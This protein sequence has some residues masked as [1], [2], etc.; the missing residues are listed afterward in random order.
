M[1]SICPPNC[2]LCL[3]WGFLNCLEKSGATPSLSP[4]GECGRTNDFSQTMELGDDGISLE[5]SCDAI[6]KLGCIEFLLKSSSMY[7]NSSIITL[8]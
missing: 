2:D 3:K 4:L 1:Q 7:Q 5:T 6:K 8:K